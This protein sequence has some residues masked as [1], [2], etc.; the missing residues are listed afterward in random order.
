M[1]RTQ[2][3]TRRQSNGNPNMMLMG[4]HYYKY[5]QKMCLRDHTTSR[6][7]L[8][9]SLLRNYRAQA[10]AARGNSSYTILSSTTTMHNKTAAAIINGIYLRLNTN[11]QHNNAASMYVPLTAMN[12]SQPP[13]L[14]QHEKSVPPGSETPFLCLPSSVPVRHDELPERW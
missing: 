6:S 12:S 14:Q 8:N 3:E 1:H 11:H 13:I 10:R 2:T 7:L 9:R 4:Y 5:E